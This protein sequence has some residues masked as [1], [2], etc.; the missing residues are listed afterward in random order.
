MNEFERHILKSPGYIGPSKMVNPYLRR[1][2]QLHELNLTKVEG[3]IVTCRVC[4]GGRVII[5]HH[6]NGLMEYEPCGACADPVTKRPTG[7]MPVRTDR[8]NN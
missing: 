4:R 5:N 7:I 2:P 8:R 3:G 6:S 1:M